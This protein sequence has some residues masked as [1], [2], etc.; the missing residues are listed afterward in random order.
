MVIIAASAIVWNHY[1]NK[2]PG[3]ATLV[4]GGTKISVEV[5]DT[6]EQKYQGLSGRE[7]LC[8]DCGMIFPYDRA[9][10][11]RF[12]MRGMKFPLDFIFI[13]GGKVVE[14]WEG[15]PPPAE[16][17]VAANIDSRAEADQ[18]LE[19]NAG[20]VEKNQIRIGDSAV[21]TRD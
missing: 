18:V 19:V 12:S 21:L 4:V 11:Q 15:V 10:T 7:S 9:E 14:F 6:V 3:Q 1:M 8:R 17:G 16:G 20:F 13:R 2:V 5:A